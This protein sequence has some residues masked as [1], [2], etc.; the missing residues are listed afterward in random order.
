MTEPKSRIAI[1]GLAFALLLLPVAA[2]ATDFKCGENY[3]TFR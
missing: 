2:N 3:V 1:A